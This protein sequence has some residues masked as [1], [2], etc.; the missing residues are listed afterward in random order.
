LQN[1]CLMIC[2]FTLAAWVGGAALFVVTSVHEQTFGQFDS[3]TKDQLA[4]IRFP[5]YYLF[6]FALV[7]AALVTGWIGLSGKRRIIFTVLTS[8]ALATM[9]VDYFTV[10]LPLQDAI[11]PPGQVRTAEFVTLHTRSKHINQVS[12]TLSL[13]AGLLVCW[14]VSG[15]VADKK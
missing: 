13:A 12:L 4:T 2:R 9:L 6:G 15:R 11:T 10:Y 7:T 8:L 14:P 1:F 3:L 5:D